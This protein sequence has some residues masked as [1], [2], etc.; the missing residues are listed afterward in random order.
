MRQF[1]NGHRHL[2]TS[3]FRA[4]PPLRLL[5]S[6]DHCEVV[7][8]YEDEQGQPREGQRDGLPSF[9]PLDQS[10]EVGEG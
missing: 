6:L 4:H 8:R 9:D 10:A 2:R 1:L 5:K 7:D 3:P